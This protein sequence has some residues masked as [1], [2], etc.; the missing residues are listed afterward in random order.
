MHEFLKFF[1]KQNWEIS[2]SS[3]LYYKNISLGLTPNSDCTVK[4]S[5]LLYI[6][7]EITKK[8]PTFCKRVIFWEHVLARLSLRQN[9]N[10]RDSPALP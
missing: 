4:L 1:P 3:W 8:K 10:E 7:V 5:H 6:G 9:S 2:A